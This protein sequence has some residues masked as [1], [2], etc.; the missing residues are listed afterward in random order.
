MD[1]L[2]QLEK[3][4]VNISDYYSLRRRK[5]E[6]LSIINAD[7]HYSRLLSKP[8]VIDLKLRAELDKS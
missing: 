6:L 1:F 7:T 3:D 5:R 2:T 8:M 4:G